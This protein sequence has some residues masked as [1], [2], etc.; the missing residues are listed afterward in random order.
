[1]KKVFILVLTI[2]FVLSLIFV[3][4]CGGK[5]KSSDTDSTVNSDTNT[6]TSV[7]SGTD[8]GTDTSSDSDT[9]TDTNTDTDTDIDPIVPPEIKPWESTAS[10]ETIEKAEKLLASKHRLEYNE[11]GSFRVL[12]LADTHMQ[13]NAN[14]T[15]VNELKDRIKLLVDKENPNLVIFTGDNTLRATTKEDLK[16]CV[17]VIASYLEEKKVPWCHVYGNHDFESK[18]ISKAEQHEIYQSYEYCIS[19]DEGFSKERVGNYVHAVYNKDGSI[20]SVIYLLDSGE[21]SRY[22]WSYVLEDQIKWYKESSEL[23]QEYNDGKVING[24]M[25]FHVP[26]VENKYAYENRDN[27]EIV[28]YWDG[29]RNEEIHCADYESGLFNAIL[30]RGDVKA[31]VT[32]H[33]HLND[34]C[35][36]YKG[37]KLTSSPTVSDLGYHSASIQGARVFDLNAETVGTNIPT[38]VTYLIERLKPSDFEAFD[39]NVS[40]E[41]TSEQVENAYKSNGSG[42]NAIGRFD[43]AIKDGKGVDGGEAIEITRSTSDVFDISFE[44]NNKG[45]LGDNKYFVVWADFTS[46]EFEKAFFG[47]ITEV[48][49]TAPFSTKGSNTKSTFYYLPDGEGEWQELTTGESGCF[50]TSEEGSQGVNGKKGYFAFPIE[51]FI[52]DG[53]SSLYDTSLITGIYFY[54]GIKKNINYLSKPFYFDNVMLVEDYNSINS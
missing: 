11:D 44:I 50:G 47:L 22:T 37:V 3:V 19:K 17:D 51:Y 21:Y 8:T 5:D 46:T 27:K 16:A 13:P 23:L 28:S 32:G 9:N 36:N 31:V 35:Y 34:Y 12:I 4:S 30:E 54:G 6:D 25:A 43:V 26:M 52:L 24:M 48:G 20:G 49:I 45:K 42:G 41:I 29:L 39:T 18:A 10:K 53:S 38:S 7:D 33:D 15:D 1:M 2:I 14:S 40:L